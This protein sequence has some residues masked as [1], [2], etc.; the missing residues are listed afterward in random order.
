MKRTLRREIATRFTKSYGI[1]LNPNLVTSPSLT[2]AHEVDI[3]G[4]VGPHGLIRYYCP[5]DPRLL[6]EM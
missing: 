4:A 2:D 3:I 5:C 6:Q 1:P